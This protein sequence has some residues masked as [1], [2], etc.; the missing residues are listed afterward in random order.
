MKAG[1][2]AVMAGLMVASAGVAVNATGTT[3][4]T[5]KN[6]V[7]Q[8]ASEA[9]SFKT[10]LAAAQAAGLAE[11]LST[12]SPITVFAPTDE[13]FAAL[14]KDAIADLLKPENKAKLA[15]IL[16]Y[17]VLPAKV[18]SGAAMKASFADTLNGQR[19]N[20]K[21]EGGSLFVDGA[22]VVKADIGASNGVIHVI[23]KVILPESKNLAE[24]ASGVKD[25]STL[26]AAVK[27]A[28]LAEAISG[29]DALTVLAPT[30]AAFE[31]LPKEVLAS[32]LKPQNKAVLAEI[33]TYHVIAGRVFSDQALKAG[34]GKTLQG[35]EVTFMVEGSQAMVN[36]A[37]ILSTDIDASNGVVH[38][39]DTVLV[40]E[41]VL[42][43]LAA[44]QPAGMG[45]VLAADQRELVETAI[46]LGAPMFN[47]GE[48]AGCAAVYHVAAM[49]LMNDAR[50][51]RGTR[52]ALRSA[53]GEAMQQHSMS[54]RAWTLRRA[55]D[56]AMDGQMMMSSAR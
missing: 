42:K 15:S 51:D 45:P 34:K 27:A 43:K 8:V 32:L 10:L 24:L 36:N 25:L 23:D 50:T 52:M 33:I 18:E 37:K 44:G 20:L 40:P 14:G 6:N 19:I 12:T 35:G 22:K 38:V 9:G 13:A 1:F 30:N 46:S 54:D 29:K 21:V 56:Q 4:D 17:H 16:T 11:A 47:R 55:L 28:G 2:L 41:G 31:K 39:I 49:A 26:V 53:L 48:A 5:P 7:V 3:G